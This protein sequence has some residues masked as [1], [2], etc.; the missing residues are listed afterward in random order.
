MR[1]TILGSLLLFL[2][3]A[4]SAIAQG[5][6]SKP[7]RF[8]VTSPAG[9]PTDI[10]AR[11]LSAKLA[12]RLGQPIIIENRAQGR[13]IG[14]DLVAKAPADG[15]TLLFTVDTYITVNPW[16]FSNLA[17]S[18]RDFAPVSMVASLR[19][20]ILCV[21]PSV[22]ARSLRDYIGLARAKPGEISV[23]NAGSGSP[24]HLVASLFALRAGIE[25]LHVPYKGGN[26]AIT[27]L[28]SG[29]VASMLAPA[30]NAIGP[31]K[32]GR[33]IPLAVTGTQRFAPL[34]SI[35]TFAEAGLPEFN[36]NEGFWYGL[37]APAATPQAIVARLARD[38]R[39]EVAGAELQNAYR[40]IGID[41]I[42]NTPAEFAKI[43]GE[44]LARWQAVVRDARI[45]VE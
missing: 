28:M 22:Q 16:L 13:T 20:F 17:Y 36:L 19:N 11:R 31:I 3:S 37:L 4:M 7:V 1:P 41:P 42:G 35:P 10:I 9:G 29:Q 43:I 15:Y 45:K 18:P 26:L 27:D 24:A 40:A 14:P 33:M 34:P 2:C 44:D 23:A 8:I 5:Y 39:D 6:P 21:H 32:D 25:V 12:D 30:Q 38:V